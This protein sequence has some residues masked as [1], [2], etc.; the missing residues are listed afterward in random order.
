MFFFLS[1][2]CLQNS[3]TQQF[4]NRINAVNQSKVAFPNGTPLLACKLA[5]HYPPLNS[6]YA[7][8]AKS[9]CIISC[10][11]SWKVASFMN[12]L[13]SNFL[14]YFD[15]YNTPSLVVCLYYTWLQSQVLPRR[16]IKSTLRFRRRIKNQRC[17]VVDIE[18][19]AK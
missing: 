8:K 11:H 13:S 4:L 14:D 7:K 9:I 5:A 18:Y 12:G 1:F 2:S 3:I 15:F 19:N 6:F 10:Q 16:Q 17:Y